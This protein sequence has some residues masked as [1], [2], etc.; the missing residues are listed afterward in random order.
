MAVRFYSRVAKRPPFKVLLVLPVLLYL[1]VAIL[2]QT[3]NYT[4]YKIAGDEG[5]YL[6]ITDSLA[7]DGDF[8]IRNN[9]YGDSPLQR[10]MN[11]VSGDQTGGS[12]DLTEMDI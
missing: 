6:L 3:D 11:N 9:S 1:A 2:W 10:Y 7:R 8:V 12:S 4:G 5:S